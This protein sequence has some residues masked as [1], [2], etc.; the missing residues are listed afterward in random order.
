MTAILIIDNAA[1]HYGGQWIFR[2]LSFSLGAGCCALLGANGSGKSSLLRAIAGID[3]LQHGHIRIGGRLQHADDHPIRLLYGYAP[4]ADSLPNDL[5]G[6]DCLAIVARLRGLP[7]PPAATLVDAEHLDLH[8]HLQRPIASYSLGTR[9]KLALC[10]ALLGR[11]PLILLDETLSALDP[12]ALHQAQHCLQE[13][14]A[15]GSAV[16]VATHALAD[17]AAGYS[18]VLL[19]DGG[20]AG[21]WAGAAVHDGLLQQRVIASLQQRRAMTD[22]RPISAARR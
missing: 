20:L 9:C 21:D 1:R 19:L 16:L 14:A 18:R 17:V 5:H 6:A 10:L 4:P 15:N 22:D 3:R 8:R 12:L 13:V 11:P 7:E 2:D